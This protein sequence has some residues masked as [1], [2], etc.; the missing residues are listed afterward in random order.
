MA[1]P[2]LGSSFTQTKGI[3]K[4]QL[5]IILLLPR[6]R[7]IYK[8]QFSIVLLLPGP[9]RIYAG[10]FNIVLLL[11]R[12][13]RLY[14]GQFNLVLLLP[15]PRRIQKGQFYIVLFTVLFKSY[16]PIKNSLKILSFTL[17]TISALFT[18]SFQVWYKYL[19]FKLK[20]Y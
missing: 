3:Y 13:R 2:Y 12:P 4:G 19:I 8:G 7:R 9:R 20:I 15:R 1:L 14:K 6:P 11:P 10:Q 18:F 16:G 17:F 5:N